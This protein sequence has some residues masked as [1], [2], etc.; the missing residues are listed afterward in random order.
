M[1]KLTRKSL[2]WVESILNEKVKSA[3]RL[4][5]GTSSLLHLVELESYEVVLRE[6]T[7][8]EWLEEEPVIV[9]QEAKNLLEAE[10]VDVPTPKLLGVDEK[11]TLAGR[12][13]VLMSK[14]G[15]QVEVQ[16]L[17]L[18]K[19]AQAL[20]K[21][22]GIENPNITHCYWS[23]NDKTS[24]PV[25]KWSKYPEK[26]QALFTYLKETKRPE[27]N[28]SL[29]HRDFHPVN[30]LWKD[31]EVSGI[32]DWPNACLGPREFDVAHC[33]WNLTMMYGIEAADDFLE[34]YLNHSNMENYSYYWDL[35]ALKNIF[36]EEAPSVYPGWTYFGLTDLTPAL[37]IERMDT[38]LS[39]ASRDL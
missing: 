18:E 13:S 5:G 21:I 23:Y 4:E 25:V 3:E 32:V 31:G 9:S 37:M 30:A 17:N 24:N 27:Y 33:R 7:N 15:G 22:H 8:E 1:R 16:N 34:S 19:L 11:G 10:S 36:S 38:F 29:I 12:P 2:E 35:E 26:W 20:V 14:V 39:Q 28:E 6:Y